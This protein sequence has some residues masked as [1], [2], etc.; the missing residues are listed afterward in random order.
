M[1]TWPQLVAGFG[2]MKTLCLEKK[3]DPKSSI[4]PF[5][6]VPGALDHISLGL[7]GVCKREVLLQDLTHKSN[8][9]LLPINRV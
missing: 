8:G 2:L 6:E 9:C 4:W 1:T 3:S 7:P 5:T